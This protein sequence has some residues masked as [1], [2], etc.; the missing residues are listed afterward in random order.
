MHL[1]ISKKKTFYLFLFFFLVSINN[2]SILGLN[3]P[4]I[5]KIEIWTKS[6]VKVC[7]TKS[8]LWS[9]KTRCCCTTTEKWGLRIWWL[10]LTW[11]KRAI[12]KCRGTA[13]PLKVHLGLFRNQIKVASLWVR[14][15]EGR[16]SNRWNCHYPDLWQIYKNQS[17]IAQ[18]MI[19]KPFLLRVK[20]MAWH[21]SV[22]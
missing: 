18:T 13:K 14:L 15:L 10:S 5:E 16:R 20:V 8:H 1:L 7:L 17:L 21:S 4:K 9:L 6:L 12:N 3:F 2:F 11:L 19:L 22:D